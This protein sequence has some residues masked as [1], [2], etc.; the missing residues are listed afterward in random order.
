M[1]TASLHGRTA[2]VTGSAQGIGLAI[3]T[4]LAQD[5]ARIVL[6]DVAAPEQV[7]EALARVRAAG[8]PNATYLRRDLGRPEEIDALMAEAL[9]WQGGLDIVVNNAGIQHT[10]LLVDMPPERWDAILAINLSAAFHTMRLALP[11]MLARGY[12]RIVNI[13]SVHGMVASAQKGPYVAAKFGL[14]G[15]TRVAALE[16][17]AAGSSQTGG[18]TANC[19]APGWTETALIQPQITARA[20]AHGGDRTAGIKDL[21]REKQPSHRMSA[22]SEIGE[23]ATMLCQ[24][25]AH[26]IN[27]ITLPVDGGWTAQ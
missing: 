12:G 11:G 2:L 10:A 26:N 22:P 15:L 19:I 21:L 8:A 14:V 24:P 7:Q 3:A 27:G 25:W 9:A 23:V 18:V 1:S 4:R 5:G 16:C 13:A 6:H 17:A 20:Q